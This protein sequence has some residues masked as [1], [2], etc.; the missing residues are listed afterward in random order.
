MILGM[1]FCLAF[2]VTL[3]DGIKL[4]VGR[5]RPNYSALRA[6]VEFGGKGMSSYKVR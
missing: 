5:P 3:T 4:M 6:L 2:S 1:L